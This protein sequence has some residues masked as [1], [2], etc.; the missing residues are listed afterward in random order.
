MSGSA[1]AKGMLATETRNRSFFGTLANLYRSDLAFRG[2]TD[3]AVIGALVMMFL[4]PPQSVKWPWAGGGA[5]Q[6][7]GGP[8]AGLLGGLSGQQGSGASGTG[9]GTGTAVKPQPPAGAGTTG[10]VVAIPFAETFKSPRLGIGFLF[11]ID[12]AAFEKS[13]P[14]DKERLLKARQGVMLRVPDDIMEALREAD[15][16]DANVQLLRG[17]AFAMRNTEA[18]NKS[19]EALWRQA[20]AGGNAQAKA[21]LGRLLLSGRPGIEQNVDA[22]RALIEEA[23]AAGDPQ[24]LRFAGVG[25][26]SGDFGTLNPVQAAE[27]LK[28]GADGGDA[29]AMGTYARMVA[30]GIGVPSA[31]GKAAEA[32][33]RKA[34]ESGLTPAQITLGDWDIEQYKQGLKADMKDAVAWH[35]LAYEKGRSIGALVQLAYLHAAVGK[36]PPWKDDKKAFAYVRKCSGFDNRYCQ[37]N[38]GIGWNNGQFGPRNAALARAHFAISASLGHEPAKA[39]IASLD[40]A[41]SA[42]EKKKADAYEKELKGSL[43]PM[44]AEIPLQ[45][46]G[47][48]LPPPVEAAALDGSKARTDA[49]IADTEDYATCVDSKA[50]NSARTSACDRVIAKGLGRPEELGLAYFGRGYVKKIEKKVDEALAD[51][52]LALKHDPKLKGALNN[53]GNILRD[54]GEYAKALAD[55]DAALAV[56][57]KYVRAL[58]GRAAALYGLGRLDEAEASAKA[59]L[60]ESPDDQWAKRTLDTIEADRKSAARKPDEKAPAESKPSQP[61]TTSVTETADYKACEDTSAKMADR[62]VACNRVIDSGKGTPSELSTVWFGRGAALGAEGKDDAALAAYNEAIKQDP[63]SLASLYNRSLIHSKRGDLDTALADLDAALQINA[64]HKYVLSGR[65]DVLRRKGKLTEALEQ[66]RAALEVDAQFEP[67]KRTQQAI[68]ADLKRPEDRDSTS[69]KESGQA[70]SKTEAKGPPP[71]EERAAPAAP[72]EPSDP[73]TAALRERARGHLNREDY[74]SAIADYTDIIRKEKGIANDFNNRGIAYHKKGDYDRALSDY[75]RAASKAGHDG[76]PHYNQSLIYT[77]RGELDKAL[78]QI[79]AAI[80]KHGMGTAQVL[81]ERADL[82]L[83]K[84]D[85]VAALKD[86]DAMIE[87]LDSRKD[88]RPLVAR[89]HVLRGRAYQEQAAAEVARCPT[90]IPPPKKCETAVTYATALLD[91][92]TAR[93]LDPD[94]GDAH[95]RIGWIA[96]RV[97]NADLAIENYTKALKAD[98]NMSVAF[99][100]RGVLYANKRQWELAMADYTDAIRADPKNKHAWANRGVLFSNR[101]QRARAI[102]DLQESLNIDADYAYARNAL[103]RLGVRR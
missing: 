78:E 43:K 26:L 101:Q 57:A 44:P 39:Q 89:A 19:A 56:D 87:K 1:G 93:S 68:L 38:A 96:D 75:A 10:P 102:A 85:F 83:Q 27:L 98:P 3:F 50:D 4:H 32:Y 80:D 13:K 76:W 52:D 36:A 91:F 5:G 48:E 25:Y 2:M 24:A 72:A 45:Y 22:G 58:A 54:K 47:V 94:N 77:K 15:G 42:E 11:D 61:S 7:Q 79:S 55:F 23:A 20:I 86:Y 33:L 35:T 21:L 31:D 82:H 71:A 6:S 100:N 74:D 92:E 65:A 63:Q 28:K 66:V 90:L 8:A 40:A 60:N 99:N 14:Q 95:F 81:S 84:K 103:R 51:Y 64:K 9:T 88:G 97:G 70:K 59:A 41:L 73:E 37:F 12:K 30:E 53:R 17:A 46:P 34:A 69:Q 49:S 62:L 16:D 18:S 67:A 29:M